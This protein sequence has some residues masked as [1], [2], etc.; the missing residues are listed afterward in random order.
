MGAILDLAES[1]W[2]GQIPPRDMWRPTGKSEELAPGVI[3]FHT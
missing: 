2:Q 1:F 3:F